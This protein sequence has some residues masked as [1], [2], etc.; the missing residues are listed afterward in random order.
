[1]VYDSARSRVVLFGGYGYGG[2]EAQTWEWDGSRW[3]RKRPKNSPS[4][5][6]GHAMVYDAARQRTFLFG[7]Y[8]DPGAWLGDTWEWD[9]TDWREL[10]PSASPFPRTGHGMAYDAKRKRTVLFGGQ[11]LIGTS[12]Y[13]VADTFEWD[14]THW[15]LIQP[16]SA[17]SARTGHRMVYDAALGRVL[18]VDIVP[19]SSNTWGFDDVWEWDGANW[20]RVKPKNLPPNRSGFAVAYDGSR[21]RMLLHGGAD[22]RGLPYFTDTWEWV[23]DSW[24]EL[25]SNS[26]P[27]ARAGHMMVFDEARRRMVRFGGYRTALP[28]NYLA[29]DTWTWDGANWTDMP[30]MSP[31]FRYHAAMAYDAARGRTVLFGGQTGNDLRDDTFEFDGVRWI[32]MKP[33]NSPSPRAHHA[34]AYDSA[35]RRTVLFGGLDGY[36]SWAAA[37]AWEWDGVDWK[38]IRVA[39]SATP[40]YDHAMAYDPIRRRVVLFGGIAPRFQHPAD[41]WEW[42]GVRWTQRKPS[43]SPPPLNNHAMAYDATRQGIVA[44]GQPNQMWKWNGSNWNQLSPTAVPPN[45]RDYSM[46]YDSHRHRLVLFAGHMD[47]NKSFADTWEWGGEK[48]ARVQPP[49]SPSSRKFHS[50]VYDVAQRRVLLFGG[51]EG[52]SSPQTYGDTWGYAGPPAALSTSTPTLTIAKG[53]P[54]Q[55]RI[56]AGRGHANRD[57]WVLGSFTGTQPGVLWGGVRIPLM[58]DAYTE[59]TVL[60]ANSTTFPSFRGTLDAEGRATATL[61]VPPMLPHSVPFTLLHACVVYDAT[62]GRIHRATNAVSLVLQ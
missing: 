33:L 50:M 51:R 18:L 17:P 11:A 20:T 1:M 25:K 41:T 36:Q 13:K 10:K 4:K 32:R 31:P 23:G 24:V 8:G 7:G 14:G 59:L 58:P 55:L 46:V 47:V 53:G 42:D 54:Q 44:L 48:W 5:R 39:G 52:D 40:K 19:T 62:T 57:Y 9:G 49:V 15:T 60:R 35:R 12:A 61:N 16:T 22:S 6:S 27:G 56:A 26:D 43:R 34:M 3:V 45:R 37:D 21:Q 38:R 2:T 30:P 29:R 28:W